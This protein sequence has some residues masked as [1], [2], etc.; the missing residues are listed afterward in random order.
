MPV[1]KEK[2]LI[3]GD[4]A[5]SKP[6]AWVM[7][8]KK[9][10]PKVEQTIPIRII[11]AP[12]KK[13]PARPMEK[14]TA[15]IE[16]VAQRMI[17]EKK[18]RINYPPVVQAKNDRNAANPRPGSPQ[19]IKNITAK[20]DPG[21]SLDEYKKKLAYEQEHIQIEYEKTM[22][23]RDALQELY[24]QR[25][26]EYE[27]VKR[28][29]EFLTDFH[30]PEM[31]YF[32]ISAWILRNR[33]DTVSAIMALK[34][35]GKTLSNK[36]RNRLMHALNGNMAMQATCI[37]LAGAALTY[38]IR[39]NQMAVAT[40]VY[41]HE[42]RITGHVVHTAAP[43]AEAIAEENADAELAAN[44]V[45]GNIADLINRVRTQNEEFQA[46][47]LAQRNNFQRE[48][49]EQRLA[50]ERADREA[51]WTRARQPTLKVDPPEYYKGDPEEIDTWLRRMNYYFGQ[52]NVT[53][54]FTRMTYAIQR[55]RKGKNN[56]AANWANGKIGE[57]ALF[58]EERAT[59]I[60]TYP[61][62][63]YTTEEIFTVIPEVAATAKHEAWPA[64]EFVHKPPFWSWDDFAQQA[65]DYFLT[66]ETRDM[67]IKKLRGTTQKGDIEEYLTEFKGWAN[68]AGFD[69]VAL[70]D[71]F[72]TGLKKGLGRRIMETGNPGDGTTP[73]Q[74][75]EWY[76][77]AL[78]L[79]KAY[80]EAE[81]YYGKK[82]FTFKGKFKP[83]NATA[84]PSTSQ[85]VTVKVKDENAMDVDKTTTTRPPPRCYNCQKMGHIAKHC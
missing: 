56:R 53:N 8:P 9:E 7:R 24:K 20:K 39:R 47:L 16:A 50:I 62:R 67:A 58:D 31:R 43:S 64:Y 1:L 22:E 48:L 46:E 79:E 71:Q 11:S 49:Q 36:E 26:E 33:F 59:F 66:T 6:L 76:K 45:G 51:E 60:T 75:Q 40:P 41:N 72:K 38:L 3:K 61:A 10:V 73:G 81:Q 14:K 70:V 19:H 63:V 82:E 78:E 5:V 29:M 68:L 15:K 44:V 23:Q 84:G 77:K 18:I 12:M 32:I 52:V 57:Q 34:H 17:Q 37:A 54:T 83:K 2:V 80:R 42:G 25:A 74:L 55:I 28:F 21:V 69:D 30:N 13:V 4:V 27:T 65:R 85:T 35:H